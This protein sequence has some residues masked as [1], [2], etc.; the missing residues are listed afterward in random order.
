EWFTITVKGKGSH[1]AEPWNGIDPIVVSAQIIQGLQAIVSRQENLPKA[2]VIITVGKIEGGVRNNIVPETVTMYGTI[3]TLDTAMQRDVRERI[4][5]T[6]T[7]IAEA[8]GATATVDI[9]TKTLVTYNDPDLVEE[10][11]PSLRK[12]AGAD[13]VSPRGWITGGE[14]FSY[15]G[16]KAPAFYF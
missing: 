12:A 1:G 14:D 11:L 3:R 9:V 7:N 15:F 10:M 5:R 4:R 8:S 2:P 16:T 13:N 6:V